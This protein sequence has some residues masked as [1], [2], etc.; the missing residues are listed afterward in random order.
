MSNKNTIILTVHNKQATIR[1][2]LDGLVK[3][4]SDHSRRI[5]IILDGCT[6]E[7]KN[8]VDSFVYNAPKK[9]DISIVETADIWETKANNVGLRMV[10]TPY[11]TIMQDD[12][13]MREI[14][15]DRKLLNVFSRI[16]VF[17]VTGRTAHEFSLKSGSY[18]SV[19]LGGREYPFGSIN[20]LSKL[21]AKLMA[22]SEPYWLFQYIAPLS[23]RIVANRGP[24]V[25]RMELA[26]DLE[27][28][29]EAF[30]PFE[31]DDVD[32]CCRA[33]KLYGLL[34]ASK[35][36]YYLE[37]GGSKK[38][39]LKS[40]EASKHSINKNTQILIQRHSDLAR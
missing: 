11:A 27:F 8:I 35:P 14:H 21:I 4:L 23:I 19:N 32:L 28:F 25:L 7:T 37:I 9:F 22:I 17:A 34:S 15:W 36:V 31:L 39:V 30:A 24:L 1:M 6:D 26:K 2:V 13:L 38:F 5:I 18:S 20:L 33:F 40:N 10:K 16:N 3:T 29:D 12:M